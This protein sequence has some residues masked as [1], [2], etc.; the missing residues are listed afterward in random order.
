MCANFD[1]PVGYNSNLESVTHYTLDK[2]VI[3]FSILIACEQ[4]QDLYNELFSSK[5]VKSVRD[6]KYK[7]DFPGDGKPQGKK[8]LKA[9]DL[10]CKEIDTLQFCDCFQVYGEN[11]P[12]CSRGCLDLKLD[13]INFFFFT[14]RI[15]VQYLQD[16][17]DEWYSSKNILY[18]RDVQYNIGYYRPE[19][20]SLLELRA[21]KEWAIM[22]CRNFLKFCKKQPPNCKMK[23]CSQCCSIGKNKNFFLRLLRRDYKYLPK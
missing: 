11:C 23:S 13:E 6:I 1:P 17:Y 4:I 15:F 2:Q 18:V 8:S 5:N 9:I 19:V 20:R 10:D 14:L 3:I 7:K 22:A 16:L 12:I 21:E